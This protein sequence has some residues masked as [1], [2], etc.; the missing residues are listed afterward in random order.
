MSFLVRIPTS[1]PPLE[2]IIKRKKVF[3]NILY[4]FGRIMGRR[5]EGMVEKD[6]KDAFIIS[7]TAI[8][9]LD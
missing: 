1:I 8:F 3:V 4:N 9:S 5:I 2:D 6:M 7:R